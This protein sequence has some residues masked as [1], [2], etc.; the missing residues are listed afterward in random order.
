M[1]KLIFLIFFCFISVNLFSQTVTNA[2]GS[3]KFRGNVAI[4]VEGRSFTF[5]NEQYV[6][7]VDDELITALKTSIRLL[8]MQK[9]QDIC[10]AVVNRD[11]DA[12][13]QVSQLIHEN[14]MED[15]IDG[16]SVAAKNQGA[17]YLFLVDITNYGE[18]DAAVQI[19]ISTRLMNVEN[20]LGYHTFYRSNAI[21]LNDEKSMRK[22]ARNIIKDFSASIDDFL[23]NIFPEQYYIANAKGKIWD[24]SAYQPNGRI[25]PTDKFYA[26]RFKKENMQLGQ[27]VM[28]IQILEKVSECKDPS[29]NGGYLQVKSDKTITDA[30]NIVLF[31]NVSQPI[32]QGVNQITM[33]FFGLDF[34][35]ETYDDLIK[36]RINNA[37]YSAITRH[38]GL[39]LVE[40]DH[41]SNL[42]KERELQK[43]EDFIDGHVVEQ[44]KAIGAIYLLKLESYERKDMQV[45]FKMSIIS[46][47]E[48]RIIKTMNITTSIDNIENEMYKQICDRIA[49][50]CTI[51]Q[52]DKNTLE[53]T[54]VITLK[55]GDGCVLSKTEAIKNPISGEISYSKVKL[56]TATVEEYCGNRCVLSI[57]KVLSDKDMNNLEVDSS[58]G[59]I[60]F[61][62]DGSKI[63]SEA[64]TQSDVKK[65]A[66]KT[67]KKEKQK[68]FWNSLKQ[69]GK[70]VLK[71]VKQNTK[72]NIN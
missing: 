11:N 60:T 58:N 31:R 2:D 38:A 14:K 13:N 40:H 61:I 24:L 62:V 43:S 44:M 69:V 59:L 52:L 46:I 47:A 35:M 29:L 18:N 48:N 50:Y 10:F 42:K 32:F 57:D 45:N 34:G 70:E 53:M 71:D 64:D 5:K 51:K 37:T 12:F 16:I 19:E 7:Q 28:P 55:E 1:K 39:Q 4:L 54:T 67:E 25:L 41:L 66:V 26:F 72:V 65:E 23:L 30:S 20:N 27:T 68:K 8:C 33:T 21:S 3:L 36:S 9:F 22:N 6:R 63:R 56:C 17:D 49:N 15:Y